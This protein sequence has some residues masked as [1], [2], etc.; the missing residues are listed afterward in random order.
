M[1]ESKLIK[2]GFSKNEA[3]IY[4]ALI[5]IGS[6]NA[7]LLATK[8]GVHRTN[9]YDALDRLIEK[10]LVSYIYKGNKRFFEASN[11]N[12]IMDRL[13]DNIN[14]FEEILPELLLDHKM[15][16][17]KDVAHIYEGIKGIKVITDDQIREGKEILTFGLSK[18]VPGK[19]K[20]FISL[21]HKKRIS[22][23]IKQKHVYDNDAVERT[24]WLNSLPYTEALILSTMKDS[25]ASTTIYGN[26][27][28]FFI[29]SE[30]VL[31]I[32]IESKRMADSY[33]KHFN[34]LYELAKEEKRLKKILKR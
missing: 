15:A 29:W 30:D 23:K 16:E 7:G 6:S 5:K 26:K 21:Y 18:D 1:R 4:L 17:K 22:K 33:R 20:S 8:S 11:P 32:V 19:M 13:K 31:G 34:V 3:K 28:A 12:K 27:V 2:L 24:K 25:P 14:S 10:G 9:V